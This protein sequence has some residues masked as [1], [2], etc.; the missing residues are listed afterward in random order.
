M[1][2]T[3]LR[4]ESCAIQYLQEIS[5]PL[6][7]VLCSTNLKER[8]EAL[9]IRI[10]RAQTCRCHGIPLADAEKNFSRLSCSVTGCNLEAFDVIENSVQVGEKTILFLPSFYNSLKLQQ[11]TSPININVTER[12]NLASVDEGVCLLTVFNI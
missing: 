1:A 6:T 8:D 10:V 2:L 11:I 5:F 3:S 9:I 4:I 7:L 12:I